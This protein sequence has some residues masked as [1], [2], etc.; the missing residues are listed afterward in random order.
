VGRCEDLKTLV[1][2]T[3]SKGKIE[4]ISS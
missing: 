3:T 1:D 2:M 4:V